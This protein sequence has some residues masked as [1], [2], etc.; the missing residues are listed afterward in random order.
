MT[1]YNKLNITETA[2][3]EEIKSAYRK[4]AKANHPDNGGDTNEFHDINEAYEVLH[5]PIRRQRYDETGD[6]SESPPKESKKMTF[7]NMHIIPLFE[8]AT[9]V[10]FDFI[11]EA[12]KVIRDIILKG[13]KQRMQN[14][15]AV[16]RF[17]Q[18]IRRI[19]R[20]DGENII[21][22]ILTSKVVAIN[23][24]TTGIDE[25]LDLIEEVLEEIET[26]KYEF[27]EEDPKEWTAA[28]TRFG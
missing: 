1:L 13:E 5:D 15:A 11:S 2:T 6:Y 19:E 3:E 17:E 23:A 8:R 7:M 18:N 25:E 16:E 26:Y 28:W 27:T 21:K 22:A 14:N 12:T 20:K 24:M 4:M 9:S 10:D